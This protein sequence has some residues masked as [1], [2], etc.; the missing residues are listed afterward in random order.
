HRVAS[1]EAVEHLGVLDFKRHFHCLH[2]AGDVLVA[3]FD[4]FLGHVHGNNLSL[5]VVDFLLG[6]IVPV[7]SDECQTNQ[8]K[9]DGHQYWSHGDVLS[10]KVGERTA[11]ATTSALSDLARLAAISHVLASRAA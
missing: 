6:S 11:P 7:A 3:E 9:G 2:E 1:L 8:H 10:V 5:D 4:R